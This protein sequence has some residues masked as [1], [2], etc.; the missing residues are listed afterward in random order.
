MSFSSRAEYDQAVAAWAAD[1][2]K[3]L[4]DYLVS[5]SGQGLFS[6]ELFYKFQ[7]LLKWGLYMPLPWQ[8]GYPMTSRN[9][10][11]FITNVSVLY[12][13]YL[14]DSFDNVKGGMEYV[15]PIETDLQDKPSMIIKSASRFGKILK[16][17][18]I[19]A[20]VV[21]IAACAIAIAGAGTAAGTAAGATSATASAT[22]PAVTTAASTGTMVSTASSTI[23]NAAT[24]AAITNTATVAATNMTLGA[25]ALALAKSAVVWVAKDAAMSKVSEKIVEKVVEKKTEGNVAALQAQ[26][27]ASAERVY[28]M[29]QEASAARIAA[30]EAETER[31]NNVAAGQSVNWLSNPLV[32]TGLALAVK[33][34][35]T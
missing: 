19:V 13:A 24:G 30:I 32:L 23:I 29:E 27:D 21:M 25:K 8:L 35:L 1:T 10:E 4:S 15:D 34:F 33:V 31:L 28:A 6:F 14:A 16:I 18:I 11:A 17:V 12:D 7:K 22:V 9:R 26:A 20:A 3:Q 5:V 2:E